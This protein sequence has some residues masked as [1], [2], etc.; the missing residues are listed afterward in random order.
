MAKT[1]T[2]KDN[3]TKQLPRFKVLLHNDDENQATDIVD[4]IREFLPSIQE[5]RAIDIV[6]EA[7]KNN[8]AILV[9]THKEHAELI[10]DQFGSCVPVINVSYEAM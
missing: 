4:R 9:I 5:S 2:D 1:N 7:H 8:K 6:K 10:V 3:K